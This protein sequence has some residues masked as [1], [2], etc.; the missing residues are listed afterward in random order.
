M[1]QNTR[2]GKSSVDVLIRS[3]L[4]TIDS[5]ADGLNSYQMPECESFSEED[6]EYNQN[7]LNLFFATVDDELSRGDQSE[8]IRFKTRLGRG[9][10]WYSHFEELLPVFEQKRN[11][12]LSKANKSEQ[13]ISQLPLS[14]LTTEQETELVTH[15]QEQIDY[16]TTIA[17]NYQVLTWNARAAMFLI[18]S[19]KQFIADYLAEFHT[20]TDQDPV[21]VE[22][23]RK[24]RK[25]ER[26]THKQQ[27]VLAVWLGLDKHP[28]LIDLKPKER[29]TILGEL[30]NRSVDDT[31]NMLN[32]ETSKGDD[33]LNWDTEYERGKVRL[34]LQGNGINSTD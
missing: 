26:L 11:S 9:W 19:S 17:K 14:N 24:S 34:F 27:M 4:P 16:C 7:R 29:G 20:S 13:I 15:H 33:K 5:S 23:G 30:L 6:E 8:L 31:E 10:E 18:L 25:K 22:P 3:L 2:P 1:Y 12:Y 21:P 28:L 32:P